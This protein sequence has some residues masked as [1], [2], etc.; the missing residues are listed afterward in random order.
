M[1][2]STK[3]KVE[4]LIIDITLQLGSI[5]C[6]SIREIEGF[7][8]LSNCKVKK[9]ITELL[10]E[11]EIEYR[12]EN[13]STDEDEPI[14]YCGYGMTEKGKSSEKYQKARLKENRV[15]GE[16]FGKKEKMQCIEH[17]EDSL[18]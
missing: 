8:N 1:D 6:I 7:L 11:G 15:R 12:K 13:I 16:C 2:N 5:G 3:D 18:K 10:K 9:V 17:I 14:I 4:E